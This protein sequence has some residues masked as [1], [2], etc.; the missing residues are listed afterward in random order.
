MKYVY[1]VIFAGFLLILGNVRAEDGKKAFDSLNCAS[2]HKV[3][4]G[5]ANPSLKEIALAYKGKENQLQGYLKGETEAVVNPKKG[6]IMR[7]YIEKTK[8]LT[9]GER[10]AL[11]GFILSHGD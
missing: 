4:T 9:D 6:G 3:D 10:K 11:S 2:C 8:G 7:R 5:K 1:L